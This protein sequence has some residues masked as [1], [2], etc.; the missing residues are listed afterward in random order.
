MMRGLPAS[1]KSTR[2][3]QMLQEFG[4]GNAKRVNKDDLRAMLDDGKWS[5]ANEKFLLGV[6]DYIISNA[7]NAG[8][9]VIVDDT[10]LP[11]KHEVRLRELAK[12]SGASFEVVDFTGVPLEECIERDRKRP[13]Y[14]G[15][16]VIRGMWEQFLRHH[17]APYPHDDNLPSAVLVDVDGTLAIMNGRGPFEWDKVDS[18]LPRF[19]VWSVA[20]AFAV[21]KNAQV[22]LVSG[23]DEVCCAQTHIW[24]AKHFGMT[25]PLHMRRAGDMRKDTIVKREI[26]EQHI[27]GQYNVLAVFDDRPQVIREWQSLGLR[28]RIF[29]VG[30]GTEF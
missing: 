18:D 8:K 12:A 10:N 20:Y 7:L 27:R 1:G 3:K 24:M 9:H 14:V 26:F 28:D 19:A 29:N 2:A 6:R 21:A 4:S 22:I 17:E 16:R 15:E 5:G 25:F 11:T 30:D 23:R 13:N